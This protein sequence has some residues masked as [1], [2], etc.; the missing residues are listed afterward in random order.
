[1][2]R[3][4][5]RAFAPRRAAARGTALV[6]IAARLALAGLIAL[7][8]I[9]ARDAPATR[10]RAEAMRGDR[11]EAVPGEWFLRQRAYPFGEI[12]TDRV[13][14]ALASA[15]RLRDDAAAAA[16]AGGGPVWRP[17]GPTNVGGRVSAIVA[18]PGADTVWL[19]AANGGVWRSN[20]GGLTWGC[21]TDRAPIT[22]IGA[23]AMD[24]TDA[25]V[26][27]AGTGEASSSVSTY[28]GNGV[29]VTRDAGATWA[30][31][32]LTETRRIAAVAV[33]PR[34]PRR[35][36][37]AAMG[38]L[39]SKDA[40][41]GLYR[42][43][44]GGAHWTK[45]LF[46]NDSTGACD[47]QVNPA[48]P[49]TVWCATWERIRRDGTRRYAGPGGGVWR[50]VNGGATWTKL[51]GGLPPSDDDLGRIAL[52]VAPSRP[53]TVYARI[54]GGEA[55]D[56]MGLGLWRTDDGGGTWSRRDSGGLFTSAFLS[57]GWYFGEL[58]VDPSDADRVWVPGVNLLL[59]HDGGA[60]FASRRGSAHVDQHAVWVDPDDP[61]HVLLG[62]DG[63]FYSSRDMG[64]TW[65]RATDLPLTQF[66]AGS[67]AAENPD[68]LLGGTQD[69][70]SLVTAGD[71]A[72][73]LS[74][75]RGD[76][77]VTFSDP[78]QPNV[79]F[80]EWQNACGRTGPRR[81]TNGGASFSA[82]S[83]F[84]L[85]D[86]YN[87]C[88]PLAMNPANRFELIA[89]SQRVYRST[90]HGVSWAPVSGDLSRGGDGSDAFGT[91]SAL[92]ISAAD[93][94]TFLAG[95]DDGR[96]WRSG[97]RGATWQEIT[98][99]LPVRWITRVVCDPVD[100]DVYYVT[101]S[102]F[103]RDERTPHV[104]RTA[105]RGAWWEPIAGNLPDLPVNDLVVD[106]L[107]RRTLFAATDGGVY[108]TRNLGA[109]W[110][111]LGAGL[112]TTAVLDLDLHPGARRLAA[113]T[114][115]RS[116]W[117][118]DLA[119]LPVAAPADAPALALAGPWPN[120]SRGSVRFEL[121]LARPAALDA[122]VFDAG[123]RHV[124]TLAAGARGAGRHAL[125]WD[126]RDARGA[127]VR[128]GVYWLRATA[129]GASRSA[130]IVRAK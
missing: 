103:G 100:R 88:A 69:N 72:G 48:H 7:A 123:G 51:G 109:T 16:A 36:F 22:S 25:R 106:P 10:D 14:D 37:V 84:A 96:V 20:D 113:F 97:D 26:V 53:R 98:A 73:W 79:I 12:P 1:M 99:N 126:G 59:S 115:G 9:V 127:S 68:R 18:A 122:A 87:W 33:D 94:A 114:H 64:A 2:R 44:D 85:G 65:R 19:G 35:L 74:T 45:V 125:A 52:A 63:G 55:Q 32:G 46:V 13:H 75:L 95:T 124:A 104:W 121:T 90:D 117:T 62:N 86:R 110:S 81:S 128:A 92:T 29:W 3:A 23:L 58:A 21:T 82:P 118:L 49:E 41:R 11:G 61:F 116:A 54:V 89:G 108:R 28:D 107:D 112:P 93:P 57:F 129:D 60:T 101:L 4:F 42:S 119:T 102:G 67:I 6:R 71:P 130:R 8:A 17:A 105:W 70:N 47:V 34:D 91:L 111:A 15:V 56:H 5:A 40:H 38:G 83:G 76:G 120:P 77:F 78:V 43:T 27:Y 39:Y 50:S 66:Y 24:P 31:L 80:A 30:H